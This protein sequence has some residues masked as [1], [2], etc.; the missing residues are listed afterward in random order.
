[1]GLRR[2]A[3]VIAGILLPNLVVAGLGVSTAQ[4]RVICTALADGGTGKILQ[5]QGDCGTRVTPAST[6][7]IAISLMG[8]E[9]QF[10]KDEHSPALPFHA[11]YADWLPAWRQ[12]T[13]P[14]SWIKYSVVWFSQQ[15][16]QSLGTARFQKYVT[17]FHYGNEDVSGDPGKHNGLTRAW[18]SSSL[19]ISPLEQLGFLEKLVTRQLPVSS[20]ALEMTKRITEITVLPNGW[21]I[22]GKTGA[23]SPPTPDGSYDEAH[24][25]GWFVGWATK[26]SRTIVFARLVQDE[27]QEAMSPGLRT[28]AAMLTE[29]P[30]LLEALEK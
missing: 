21:D 6:F 19:R 1:M 30:A 28:R 18:L 11:G 13:D 10:L 22:H 12:T 26:G 14:T 24:S 2:V 25:Y 9:S 8:Y 23:G 27:K 3:S 4:A 17:D 20:H 7:K 16:T 15:V 29:L 5:Q